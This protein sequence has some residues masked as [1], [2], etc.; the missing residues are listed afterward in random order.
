MVGRWRGGGPIDGH[1]APV[2]AEDMNERPQFED[3]VGPAQRRTPTHTVTA[4]ARCSGC[5]TTALLTTI[6]ARLGKWPELPAGWSWC[7]ETADGEA[8]LWCG[9]CTFER[10]FDR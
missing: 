8:A 5:P 7:G 6:Q 3:H 1:H 4:R 10:R 2:A 9:Q